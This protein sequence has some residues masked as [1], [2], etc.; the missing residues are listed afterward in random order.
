MNVLPVYDDR[1]VKTKIGKNGDKVYTI[2]C[3][4]NVPED[5]VEC[6]LKLMMGFINAVLL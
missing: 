3:G 6:E 5:D 2:L 1:Y 4:L